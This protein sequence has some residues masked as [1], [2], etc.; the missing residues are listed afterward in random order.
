MREEVLPPIGSAKTRAHLVA[1]AKKLEKAHKQ[2]CERMVELFCHPDAT[3][4]QVLLARKTMMPLYLETRKSLQK[5]RA[6]L[7]NPY[8]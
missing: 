1:H 8:A 6:Q 2:L 5:V 3:D 7:G 4:E